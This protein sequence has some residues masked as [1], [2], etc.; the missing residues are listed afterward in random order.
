M[1]KLCTELPIV[2]QETFLEKSVLGKTG[3]NFVLQS[4]RKKTEEW[5]EKTGLKQRKDRVNTGKRG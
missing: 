2:A 3:N 1:Y 4:A 5:K